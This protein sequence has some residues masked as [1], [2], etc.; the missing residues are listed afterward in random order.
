M[1]KHIKIRVSGKVQGVFFRASTKEKAD[2]LGVRGMV[3]NE[4]DGSVFIDAEADETILAEF[5]NWCKKGPDRAKVTSVDV[6]ESETL[7]NYS[8]FL[9]QR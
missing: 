4:A 3:R 7:K 9:I 8:S 1:T 2:E 6:Q 5:V